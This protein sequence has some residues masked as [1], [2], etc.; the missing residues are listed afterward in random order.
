MLFSFPN[1][2]VFADDVEGSK[3]NDNH[4]GNLEPKI[5]D[6]APKED[7]IETCE[8]KDEGE[9]E[10]LHHKASEIPSVLGK[11]SHD[12]D[13]PTSKA[14]KAKSK[15]STDSESENSDV[16]KG[17]NGLANHNR[18]CYANSVLQML[19]TIKP[20][21]AHCMTADRPPSML[22]TDPATDSRVRKMC[23]SVKRKAALCEIMKKLW[24]QRKLPDMHNKMT[25]RLSMILEAIAGAEDVDNEQLDK[26][27]PQMFHQ[28]FASSQWCTGARSSEWNGEQPQESAEYFDRLLRQLI[29]EADREG[30]RAIAE[31][32]SV[33]TR[34]EIKC[35]ACGEVSRQATISA[36][37]LSADLPRGKGG[38]IL[39]KAI[40]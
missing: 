10:P 11:R 21:R 3:V 29:I 22:F 17:P 35:P 23:S 33:K 40:G 4:E 20:L 34:T 28:C 19:V 30:E 38:H 16:A 24:E 37:T 13:I 39:R 15:S 25:P 9:K 7:D 27:L 31:M 32:F 2:R 12:D 14:K 8:F 6:D 5:I 36:L 18:A 26:L 1:E